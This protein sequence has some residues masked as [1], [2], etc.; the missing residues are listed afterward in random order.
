M[1]L[2]KQNNEFFLEPLKFKRRNF[3]VKSDWDS[4][5]LKTCKLRVISKKY[6]MDFSRKIM[7]FFI[8]SKCIKFAAELDWDS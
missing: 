7:I 6:F 1:G 4:K 2:S 5:N 8:I 3:A